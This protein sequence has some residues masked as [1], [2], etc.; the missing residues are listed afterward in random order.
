MFQPTSTKNNSSTFCLSEPADCFSLEHSVGT[1]ICQEQDQMN[2]LFNTDVLC[3]VNGNFIKPTKDEVSFDDQL[4]YATFLFKIWTGTATTQVATGEGSESLVRCRIVP[5]ACLKPFSDLRYRVKRYCEQCGEKYLNGYVFSR[6]DLRKLETF[7]QG[8]SDHFYFERDRKFAEI[9]TKLKKEREVDGITPEG[10]SPDVE[11]PPLEFVL[12][13][14]TFEHAIFPMGDGLNGGRASIS[15]F[16]DSLAVK[17]SAEAGELL[18]QLQGM[19]IPTEGFLCRAHALAARLDTWKRYRKSWTT[20]CFYLKTASAGFLS[21]TPCE[22]DIGKLQRALSSIVEL[23][24]LANADAESCADNNREGATAI[25]QNDISETSF[26]LA[27]STETDTALFGLTPEAKE[28]FLNALKQISSDSTEFS[29]KE[30]AEM[31]DT[32]DADVPESEKFECSI[33]SMIARGRSLFL[34]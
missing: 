16:L 19:T 12:Q 8:A 4:L 23:Q 31:P 33:E 30:I 6:K 2:S 27:K 34:G 13:Q 26:P 11:A 32:A 24:N 9:Y 25:Q 28:R 21:R 18:D 5:T 29:A 3:D 22:K 20:P 17:L 14:I 7:L 15:S 10:C 1:P